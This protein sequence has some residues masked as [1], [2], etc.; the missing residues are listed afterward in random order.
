MQHIR[1]NDTTSDIIASFGVWTING[2]L[3]FTESAYFSSESILLCIFYERKL[4]ECNGQILII[5]GHQRGIMK[6]WLK[7]VEN[8]PSTSQQKW[9]LV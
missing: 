1:I 8:D 5:T 7:Q 4:Q 3:Y 2:E 9:S 6:F